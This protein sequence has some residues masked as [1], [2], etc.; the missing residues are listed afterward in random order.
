MA[1]GTG[2]GKT[3]TAAAILKLFYKTGNARRILFLVDRLELENQAKKDM[4]TYLKNDF[5][6]KKSL[7]KNN[8]SSFENSLIY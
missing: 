3:L 8:K 1:T 2:T 6:T 5:S 4:D 7:V